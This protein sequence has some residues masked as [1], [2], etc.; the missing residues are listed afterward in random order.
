MTN[1]L[2]MNKKEPMSFEELKEERRSHKKLATGVILLLLIAVN[3]DVFPQI[4]A[5][6]FS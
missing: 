4:W 1:V 5:T 3:W 6:I 2:Y